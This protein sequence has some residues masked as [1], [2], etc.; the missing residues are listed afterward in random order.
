MFNHYRIKSGLAL[1]ALLAAVTLPAHAD[2]IWSINYAKSHFGPGANAL[3]LERG[4]K[5]P[6]GPNSTA[7]SASGS[8]LVISGGKI[9]MA[10]DEEALAAAPGVRKVEYSRWRDMKLVLI[11]DHVRPQAYCDFRC[12]SGFASNSVTLNFTAHGQDPTE[13]MKEMVAI[14]SR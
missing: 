4:G 10:V 3:V 12:Q 6:A 13:T 9:Y 7:L 14:S 1:A 8:F 2:E 11:G 5:I